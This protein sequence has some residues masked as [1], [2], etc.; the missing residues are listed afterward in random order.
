MEPPPALTALP[1]PK[2]ADCAELTR[3]RKQLTARRPTMI[4]KLQGVALEEPIPHPEGLSPLL[5]EYP[6]VAAAVGKLRRGTAAT[7]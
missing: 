5:D 7:R 6:R 3:L 4:Y 1:T 2:P